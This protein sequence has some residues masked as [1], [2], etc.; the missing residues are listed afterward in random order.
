MPANPLAILDDI[1]T[2]IAHLPP[3]AL[4][5][6]LELVETVVKSD[7]PAEAAKRGAIAAASSQVSEATLREL[8]R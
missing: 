2:T 1:G 8:L 4:G 6:I 3:H 5:A 7:N